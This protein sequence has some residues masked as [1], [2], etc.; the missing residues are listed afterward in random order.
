MTRKEAIEVLNMVEAHGLADEAKQM[1]IQALQAQADCNTC[2]KAVRNRVGVIGCVKFDSK[3][4]VAIPSAEPCEDAISREELLKA[5]DTWD[6]FGVDDTNSLFRL[7]NLS[8]AHYVPYIHYDDV[9]KCI[10]AMPSVKQEPK[11]GHWKRISIDKY[12]EHAKYWYR[13]DRCGKDNLGNTDW[14]PNCGA[15]MVEPQESEVRNG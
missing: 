3:P 1:A 12:C 10:E 6:R 9:I 13:C 4:T 8:L 7:D 15:K 2:D 14:C 11:T 5:I